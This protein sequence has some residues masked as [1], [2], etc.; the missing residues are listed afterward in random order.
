MSAVFDRDYYLG[1]GDRD[2]SEI[3]TIKDRVAYVLNRDPRTR[4]S[5]KLLWV[6]VLKTF[7][8]IEPASWT[9]EQVIESKLP[10]EKSVA[11]IRAF[12]QNKNLVYLPTSPEVI[13]HRLGRRR[14]YERVFSSPEFID[15]EEIRSERILKIYSDESGKNGAY[16]IMGMYF[17]LLSHDRF[18]AYKNIQELELSGRLTTKALSFKQLNRHNVDDALILLKTLL[19]EASA[20][21]HLYIWENSSLIGQGDRYLAYAYELSILNVIDMLS[22]RGDIS[23]GHGIELCLDDGLSNMELRFIEARLLPQIDQRHLVV[24]SHITQVD[25]KSNRFVQAADLLAGTINR[26]INEEGMNQNAKDYFAKEALKLISIECDD[27][28]S[29]T[30][31][32]TPSQLVK[33]NVLVKRM[34]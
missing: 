34:A 27:L 5:D 23:R 26:V 24:S 32:A 33:N 16:T 9:L 7:Y 3:N 14:A 12:F 4:N 8:E 25:D 31:G 20:Q 2:I 15:S 22:Q 21:A 13:T 1:I 17:T 29:L 10:T 11:R 30:S 6:E 19:Q 18:R 28:R